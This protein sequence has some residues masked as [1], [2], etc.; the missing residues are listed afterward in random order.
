MGT[1]RAF[2]NTEDTEFERW[3]PPLVDADWHALCQAIYT[4]IEGKEWEEL[5]CH[6]RDMSKATGAKKPNESEQ[7]KALWAMKADW[8]R[9]EESYDPARKE[10]ILGKKKKRLDLWEEHLK[11]P[12]AAL[13]KALE[14]LENLFQCW[15]LVRSLVASRG[16]C[17]GLQYCGREDFAK[18][19]RRALLGRR[20]AL[21][22]P[23]GGGALAHI[24]QFL[25]RPE[26]VRAARRALLLHREG[27]GGSHE[28]S[29]VQALRLCGNA[30]GVCADWLTPFGSRREAGSSGSQSPDLGDMWRYGCPK[31]LD[32]GSDGESWS[33]SEGLS[34]SDSREHNVESLA[35]NVIGQSWLGEKV[36]LF[37]EA[38]E[39]ARVALSCHIA[40]DMCQCLR[41]CSW[42]AAMEACHSKE[43]PSPWTGCDSKGEVRE[44][45]VTS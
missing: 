18:Y 14:C 35:L 11:D 23:M 4:G 38:W 45:E 5:Y 1:Q 13:A 21:L 32:W 16:D 42:V 40:L 3:G 12:I 44:I 26:V 6:Y 30:Q 39:L 37:L 2:S 20:L 10:H 27:A 28:G 8:D 22:G 29:A 33:A 19:V 34:S 17:N 31:S 15:L 9:G 36:S 41:P 43:S 7:A 25:E 24:I